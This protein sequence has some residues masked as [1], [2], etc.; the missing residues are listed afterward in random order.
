MTQPITWTDVFALGPIAVVF[1]GAL[2]VTIIESFYR[3]AERLSFW[4]TLIVLA[5]AGGIALSGVSSDGSAFGG[6]V[7]TG[8]YAWYFA[9]LFC[10]CGIL[11]AFL[12]H[13]Y[14]AK[15]QTPFGEYYL[16]LLTA[17]AGMMAMAAANDLIVFFLGLETMSI[18][19]YV[20]AGFTRAIPTSNESSLKYFLL[21][22]FAT[23]FLLYGIAL[24]YGTTGSTSIAYMRASLPAV[25]GDPVFIIGLGLLLTGFAFKVAAVPFHMWVPD[26]YEGAPTTVSAFLSTGGKA[27]AFAA[28]LIVFAPDVLLSTSGIRQVIAVIAA[29]SMILGNVL[30]ISQSSIKRMLAYSSVAHAGY[31]LTGIVAAN[32]AGENGVL[33]YLLAYT[34][35]NVGAFGVVALL[36]TSAGERRTI[37]EFAGLSRTQPVL[38]ALMALFMFSLTGIPPMAGFFGKYYVFAGAIEGGY[39]W[40][41]ILGVLMSVVSAYYYLRVVVVMYFQD[42]A[43]APAVRVPR[44]GLVALVLSALALLGLGVFPSIVVDVTA[45]FF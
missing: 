33:F 13:S 40:L 17:L 27:A 35:M 42:G 20:L 18:P 34:L 23:G 9:F 7:L 29:L 25:S 41:A 6:T 15:Q 31:L 5:L 14:L 45:R 39:T 16:L 44:L 12:S 24:V 19:F 4:M 2:L 28:L 8:G 43:A 22:S 10:V 37:D 38:A 11:V 32:A 1:A 21:G 30:A 3:T 36:E 26:V